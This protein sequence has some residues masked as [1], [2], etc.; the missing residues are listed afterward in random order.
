MTSMFAFNKEIL[1][2]SGAE[3]CVE[4]TFCSPSHS[5]LIVAVSSNL[6]V[7]SLV[8][9][10]SPDVVHSIDF[11]QSLMGEEEFPNLMPLLEPSKKGQVPTVARMELFAKFKLNGNVCSMAAIRTQTS[12]GL[13]GMDSLLISWADAK[14]SLIEF[15]MGTNSI[16]TVSLHYYEREEFKNSSLS[17]RGY[18]EIRMDPQN[19][20]AA[21]QFYQ[22]KL[23]ILPFKQESSSSNLFDSENPSEEY[24]F[25]G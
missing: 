8:E 1:A 15:N 18:P 9:E 4:A 7:Y 22:D 5:N 20:C 6:F 2:S 23:A 16:V 21:L 19:R 11:D 3:I 25:Y 10:D 13:L 24:E 17:E 14:M 12:V